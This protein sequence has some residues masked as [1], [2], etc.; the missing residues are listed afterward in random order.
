[1]HVTTT[2][3]DRKAKAKQT[4]QVHKGLL[5]FPRKKKE[6]PFKPT[7]LCSLG[8]HQL[9]YQATQ[10]VVVQIYNTTQHKG[11]P[12]TTVLWHSKLS[13]SMATT[14]PLPQRWSQRLRGQEPLSRKSSSFQGLRPVIRA[15]KAHIRKG[16]NSCRY[17][18]AFVFWILNLKFYHRCSWCMHHWK[19]GRSLT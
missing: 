12:Q 13:L 4:S 5:I 16:E 19:Q 6:L 11:K 15:C 9:S 2:R 3:W 10:L 8:K 17:R 1:M 18:Q 7:T 14:V